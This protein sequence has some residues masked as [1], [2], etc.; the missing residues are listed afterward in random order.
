MF[1]FYHPIITVKHPKT[2]NPPCEVESPILA[3][4]FPP[5]MTVDEPIEIVSGGPVQTHESPTLA[6]GIPPI[7]TVGSPGGSIGPPTCGTG[8]GS[9]MGQMCISVVL[10]AG[11]IM[12]ND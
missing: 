3:A 8:P 9:T 10:A 12:I 11:G 2:I 7:M 4:G 5:I 6:A 1:P